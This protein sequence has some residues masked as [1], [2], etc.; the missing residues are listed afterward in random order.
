MFK[1]IVVNGKYICMAYLAIFLA[2]IELDDFRPDQL[3]SERVA[4]HVKY[5]MTCVY[6][7]YFCFV[8]PLCQDP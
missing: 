1:H 3:H 4:G 8:T 2:T 7:Q 6:F 5:E